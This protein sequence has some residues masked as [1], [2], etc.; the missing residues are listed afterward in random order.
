MDHLGGLWAQASG[1]LG[2][3]LTGLSRLGFWA[4]G[5]EHLKF[6]V[7]GFFLNPHAFFQGLRFRVSP[8]PAQ[9]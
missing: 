2:L 6:R 3:E 5:V 9:D 1:F 7:Q 4:P 8:T